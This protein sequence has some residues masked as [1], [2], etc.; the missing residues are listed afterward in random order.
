MSKHECEIDL[1]SSHKVHVFVCACEIANSPNIRDEIMI[2]LQKRRNI[3]N[4]LIC[5]SAMKSIDTT[6]ISKPYYQNFWI[7]YESS[8]SQINLG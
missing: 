5:G 1:S 3:K 2:S 8:Q 4:Q 7:G 6:T